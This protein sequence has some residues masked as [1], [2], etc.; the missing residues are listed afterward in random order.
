MAKQL[1]KCGKCNTSI[2]TEGDWQ[3]VVCPECGIHIRRSPQNEKK[4]AIK[5]P[6]KLDIPEEKQRIYE[7]IA[8]AISMVIGFIF[9]FIMYPSMTSDIINDSYTM[10]DKLFTYVMCFFISAIASYMVGGVACGIYMLRNV[11]LV[12]LYFGLSLWFT[13]IVSIGCLIVI[14][15]IST[16]CG[17]FAFAW[18]FFKCIGHLFK[19][20]FKKK[21]N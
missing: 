12:I 13:G 16:A 6:S 9:F 15:G 2:E 14:M 21:N 1:I 8:V 3:E 17:W 20:I 5:K 11:N 19:L 10:G 4:D 7:F 18:Y